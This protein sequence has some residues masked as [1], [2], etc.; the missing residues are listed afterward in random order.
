MSTEDRTPFDLVAWLGTMASHIVVW[1]GKPA[2]GT[3]VANDTFFTEVFLKLLGPPAEDIVLE[4]S[5][6]PRLNPG[7]HLPWATETTRCMHAPR[8]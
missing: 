8:S 4:V 6:Y 7:V 2:V 5:I 3:Q 1:T